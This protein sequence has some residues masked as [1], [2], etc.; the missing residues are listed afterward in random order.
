M[1][2]V[3]SMLNVFLEYLDGKGQRSSNGP[4][5]GPAGLRERRSADAEPRAKFNGICAARPGRASP[6]STARPR[7]RSTSRTST[8]RPT[9]TS[10]GSDRP[11]DPQH[12]LLRHP[13]RPQ[14]AIGETGEL[15]IAG[16][17]SGAGLLNNAA[18]TAKR[19]VDNPVNPGERIYRTGDVARWLPDGNIEYLGRE[20]HQ[21]K[22]RGLRIEL[23]EIEN[24]IARYPGDHDCVA[25]VK[26]YSESVSCSSPTWCEGDAGRRGLKAHLRRRLPDYMVPHHFER[27]PR[28][29]SLER[30]GRSQRVTR[31]SHFSM[32]GASPRDPLRAH[33]FGSPP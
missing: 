15:C 7:R 19:F 33:S 1:H 8:A 5:L 20:D 24:T 11:A 3:P 6:T 12:R 30:Q 14:V 23:G 31:A 16:V 10:N 21:V 27:S 9:T 18:L 22:I 25:V 26:K 13:R 4:G 2:F 32:R 29:R 17:G 28:C